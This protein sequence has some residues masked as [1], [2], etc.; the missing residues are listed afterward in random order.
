MM[1]KFIEDHFA[2]SEI[3]LLSLQS[4]L[5]GMGK[6]ITVYTGGENKD[7]ECNGC[8]KK[9]VGGASSDVWWNK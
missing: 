5:L 4:P 9:S 7:P 2:I 8:C 6:T 1:H 3:L